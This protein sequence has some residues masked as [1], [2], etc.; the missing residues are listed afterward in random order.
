MQPRAE[1]IHRVLTAFVERRGPPEA[2]ASRRRSFSLTV[3]GSA[4]MEAR[5]RDLRGSCA[6]IDI[7][8]SI[9]TLAYEDILG[10]DPLPAAEGGLRITVKPGCFASHVA[11]RLHRSARRPWNSQ[12]HARP[13]A[14][15][16]AVTAGDPLDL[17][18]LLDTMEEGGAADSDP[19]GSARQDV[20][21]NNAS[22]ER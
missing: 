4:P 22:R 5:I 20:V 1:E 19:T 6:M 7:G 8:S 21:G 13:L 17:D 14:S 18:A 3:Q 15:P 11:A 10:L 9:F 16:Q 2:D 12:D